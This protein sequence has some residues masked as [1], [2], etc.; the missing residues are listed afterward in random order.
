M[1]HEV[2]F[3][4]SLQNVTKGPE[5]IHVLS[6]LLGHGTSRPFFCLSLWVC[7]ANQR[8]GYW[9]NLPCDWPSIAWAYSKQEAENGPTLTLGQW[10]PQDRCK[11]DLQCRSDHNTGRHWGMSPQY[12]HLGHS[13]SGH[14]SNLRMENKT[15]YKGARLT[16]LMLGQHCYSE[17]CCLK[18]QHLS[19]GFWAFLKFQ[20]WKCFNTFEF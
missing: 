19:E 1:K 17:A 3:P 11:C 6:D 2:S 20:T 5:I 13:H 4:Y 16:K 12:S 14:Q 8:P 9:S 10:S 7:S 18:L 15:D